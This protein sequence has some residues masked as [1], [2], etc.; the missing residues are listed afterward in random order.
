MTPVFGKILGPVTSSKSAWLFST[1]GDADHNGDQH[2]RLLGCRPSSSRGISPHLLHCMRQPSRQGWSSRPFGPHSQV[3]HM[4]E[5][6]IDF[7]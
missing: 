6:A 2:H 4:T 1:G 7:M 3:G 5:T